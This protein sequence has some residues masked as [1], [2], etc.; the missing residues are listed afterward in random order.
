M[1]WDIALV[2][3][4]CAKVSILVWVALC[5]VAPISKHLPVEEYAT[6]AVRVDNI[7]A[8]LAIRISAELV[9]LQQFWTVAKASRRC[10]VFDDCDGK[11][12]DGETQVIKCMVQDILPCSVHVLSECGKHWRGT[13]I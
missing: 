7:A 11:P 2:R 6:F 9:Q 3:G 10:W 1:Q 12:F 13:R 8:C 4:T 5:L